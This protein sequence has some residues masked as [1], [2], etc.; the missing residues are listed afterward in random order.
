MWDAIAT[1]LSQSSGQPFQLETRRSVSGGCINAGYAI[2][3]SQQTYFVKV[4][5]SAQLAMFK[6]EAAGLG[7]MLASQTI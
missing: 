4:N 5:Q 2:S 6:A 1:H 3:G 7:E